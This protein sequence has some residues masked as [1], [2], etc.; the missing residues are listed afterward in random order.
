[1]KRAVIYTRVSSRDQV[2]NSS[3]GAQLTACTAYCERH[4]F[5]VDRVFVEEGESAK[6]ADRT[7]L[8]H[9][10]AHC[11]QHQGRL[12]ALVVYNLSRFARDRFDHHALLAHLRGLGIVLRSVTEPVDE[13]P[14]GEL[15]DAVLAGVH[16][17]ENRLRAERVVSGMRAALEAGRWVRRPPVG[18]RSAGCGVLEED[19]ERGPLVRWLFERVATG[20]YALEEVRQRA[21]ARGLTTTAGKPLPSQTLSRMLRNPLYAG[22]VVSREW[23]IDAPA[24]F[25]PLV[26]PETWRRVQRVLDGT[27]PA[28]PPAATAAVTSRLD[29]PDFPLR[30]FLRCD[31]CGVPLTGSWSRG[32]TGARYGYYHCRTAGCRSVKAR[33]EELEQRWVAE[34]DELRPSPAYLRLLREEVLASWHRRHAAARERRTALEAKV[35]TLRDRRER[36]VE[37][38]VYERGLDRDTYRRK[39]AE[40]G[41]QL[42]LAELALQDERVD[43]LDV[44]GLLAFA[45]HVLTHAGRLWLE[46]D[47]ERRRRF[48]HH[49]FPAGIA[50]TADLAFRT[51]STSS[52]FRP[53]QGEVGEETNLVEQMGFEPT[54]PTLRTWCSPS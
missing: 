54:T 37:V 51:A 7:E 15:M 17:F 50:V 19:P 41:E 28:A 40:L 38:Y 43:E 9:L 52:L 16:A 53:L 42:T 25:E 30:R 47:P 35:C 31:D 34:L 10:L 11:R 27:P 49:L 3:L 39:S 44:E 13:T 45:E 33:R 32:S 6:T 23:A 4:G 48:Q 20:D 8:R 26:P 22:R 2:E 14:S 12:H 21:V 1:M 29:H 24:D 46:L 5:A 36:L 18:Y